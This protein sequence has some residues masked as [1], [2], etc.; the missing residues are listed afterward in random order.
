[1]K[2]CSFCN[3]R[4]SWLDV[5]TKYQVNKF[6]P[7]TGANDYLTVERARAKGRCGP[8]GKDW[9]PTFLYRLFGG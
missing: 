3:F 4:D 9:E 1:M 6:N 8:E 5:C 7:H 2:G